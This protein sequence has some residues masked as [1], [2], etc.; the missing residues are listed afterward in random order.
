[1]NKV[2]IAGDYDWRK[3]RFHLVT[4]LEDAKTEQQFQEVIARIL[5]SCGTIPEMKKRR[6]QLGI[7]PFTKEEIKEMKK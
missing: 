4:A 5:T 2:A 1:M 6:K 3:V 7:K